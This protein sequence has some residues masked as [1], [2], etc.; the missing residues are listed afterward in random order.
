[1]RRWALGREHPTFGVL[2]GWQVYDNGIDIYFESLIASLGE[3]ARRHDVNLLT[4]VA[5]GQAGWQPQPAWPNVGRNRTFAPVGPWNT[6]GLIVINPLAADETIADARRFQADGHPLVYVSAGPDGPA[7]VPDNRGGI[8]SAIEHLA[9]HGHERIA[10]LSCETGD[11]PARR[12]AYVAN[13]AALG[14]VEDP[15]LVVD[16]NHERR[17][18][19]RAIDTLLDGGVEFTAVIASNGHSGRGALM[20]LAERGLDVPNDCALIAF[21]DFVESLA[22]EPAVTSIHYPLDLAAET[23]IG[24]LLHQIENGSASAA[25]LEVRTQLVLRESCGCRP[26]YDGAA[27]ERE[28]RRMARNAVERIEVSRAVGRFAKRLLA[29]SDLDMLALGGILAETLSEAGLRGALVGGFDSADS[30]D[31]VRW[32]IASNGAGGSVRFETRTFP[33]PEL[34]PAEP[35]RLIVIPLELE[36]E[37]GFLALPSDDLTSCVAI[38][39]QTQAAFQSV[40]NARVRAE[41]EAALAESEARLRKAQ[42]L[43]AIGQLA[44]GIA[45]DFNNLLTPIVGCSELLLARADDDA[46]RRTIELIANAADRAASLTRQ[47]LAFSRRQMMQPVGLDLRAVVSEAE[48]LLSVVVGKSVELR[49]E[50]PAEPV[51]ALADRSQ[52]DQVILNLAVN[53]RDAMPDGGTL[54]VSAGRVTLD[55]EAAARAGLQPGTYAALTISDTGVGMSSDVSD[56]VFEPFFTTKGKDSTGLGLATVYGIVTQ[57]GGAVAVESAPGAGSTFSV[58]LPGAAHAQPEEQPGPQADGKRTGS[59]QT[60]LVVEDEEYVRDFVRAA[61]ETHGYDV[62]CASN[63]A[64]G[65]DICTTRAGE[66]DAVLTDMVMPTMGGKAMAERL[67]AAGTEIPI[68]FMSGY[69]EDSLADTPPG[70]NAFLAKPFGPPAL[71]ETLRGVLA[72]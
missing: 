40:R 28:R 52:L 18:G 61:L 39:A 3:A 24:E 51:C 12:D 42:R 70:T 65:L 72:A 49:V 67:R 45:H 53:A 58:Y 64:E 57:S 11:G 35:F 46:S 68:V 37:V 44:G 32:S 34:S 10:F 47:L 23:A 9:A 16:A 5:L 29:T 56:R 27:A 69:T 25:E 13:V 54:T 63:G 50:L 30:T 55:A 4:A 48:S 22:T 71:L 41:A 15:R 14:L 62:L 33:P 2:Y 38:A 6:D 43:E 17:A 19:M 7:V 20:R 59:A 31:P 36:G 21:D 8:E 1:M 66:I 60:V 26:E